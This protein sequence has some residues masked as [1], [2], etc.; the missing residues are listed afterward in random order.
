M[1]K[2]YKIDAYTKV[3]VQKMYP[4]KI[5]FHLEKSMERWLNFRRNNIY[6]QKKWKMNQEMAKG[7]EKRH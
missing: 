1:E 4:L 5:D 7:H 2:T 3:C 6:G